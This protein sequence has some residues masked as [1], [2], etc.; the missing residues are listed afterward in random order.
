[1]ADD[2]PS[3]HGND[4][5][6]NHSRDHEDGERRVE[7]AVVEV[8][9]L[10][11]GTSVV[12]VVGPAPLSAPWIKIHLQ[13]R[14][15]PLALIPAAPTPNENG[16]T[17][18]THCFNLYQG[19][20]RDDVTT[21]TSEDVTVEMSS[22][23]TTQT[24]CVPIVYLPSDDP[25]QWRDIP[26]WIR[27]YH[28]HRHVDDIGIDPAV[29]TTKLLAHV[30]DATFVTMASPRSARPRSSQQLGNEAFVHIRIHEPPLLLRH[31][32]LGKA[33][34]H[35]EPHAD[36]DEITLSCHDV[37]STRSLYLRM[38]AL[39]QNPIHIG[40]TEDAISN[41]N[42]RN[43]Q[44]KT[45]QTDM[46]LFLHSKHHH[47]RHQKIQTQI[48]P[49]SSTPNNG[50]STN[51]SRQYKNDSTKDVE[52][53]QFL[54]EGALTV[55][56]PTHGSG[57]TRL[58]CAI[59]RQWL[60]C[61]AVHVISP[62]TLFAQ[63]GI[64]ADA[65]LESMLHEIVVQRAAQ[66]QDRICI[67]LDH[68]DAFL[69]PSMSGRR[70]DPGDPSGV[71]LNA[72][73][74]YLSKLT[75]QLRDHC[76]FP[77]PSKDPMHNLCGQ[78]G[79]IFSL[80]IC[81]VGIVTCTD[82]GGQNRTNLAASKNVLS[83]LNGGRYR[84]PVL[85]ATGRLHAFQ[86][87]FRRI[88]IGLAPE[89]SQTLS[90]LAASAV[91]ARGNVF[92]RVAQQLH[93]TMTIKKHERATVQDLV[94]AFQILRGSQWNSSSE[95]TVAESA[96]E[97]GETNPIS[98]NSTTNNTLFDSVGGNVHAKTALEDALALDPIM[99]EKL[100][101]LCM[102]APT[103]VLL[104]GPPGTG[105]TLLARAIAK[106]L[107]SQSNSNSNGAGGAE[108]TGAFLTLKAS[109]IV[110]SQVGNSEKLVVSAFET[111]RSNAPAV[112]FIDEFQALF[113]DRSG[114]GSG[115]L[116][117]T[118][119]QC[120]D[121]VT[122]WKD[123]DRDASASSFSNNNTPRV[124]VLGATNAPWMVDKAFLRPG[125]FDRVVHVGLP[126]AMERESILRV[127][128]GRMKLHSKSGTDDDTSLLVNQ[129]CT[130]LSSECH[131]FSGADL[132]ALCR[133]AAVKC[134]VE[135]N[136]SQGVQLRHF[137]EAR[138]DDVTSSSSPQLVQRLQQWRK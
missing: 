12:G 5:A 33:N 32:V 51:N 55:H 106:S 23:E 124:V 90:S 30:S 109:E 127:H 2:G 112:I 82:T 138:R 79:F 57:K 67:V 64:Q 96:A 37:D 10:H 15:P 83:V 88:R 113:T 77:F 98:P 27:G 110:R 61:D 91:T 78:N 103:G 129:I 119:L 28:T 97:P 101:A 20:K 114:G 9:P 43:S 105:K 108:R 93:E 48:I 7:L 94:E 41:W 21:S 22:D 123:A 135:R 11:L 56:D 116:A 59:A 137:Q 25:T 73:A 121:D 102:S 75:L 34:H 125:R 40:T 74:S 134:L 65:G 62:G 14:V 50:D 85:T 4:H 99:R 111:A 131:G 1:M 8:I 49:Q 19:T 31:A 104:Y 3:S 87:A 72:I 117:S 132:A 118:L 66:N 115:R 6:N 86:C 52:S 100:S 16:T 38:K 60:H 44:R 95:V 68:L 58:V 36:Q 47:P 42:T 71:V 133:A 92:Q 136:E 107:R 29:A 84:L 76:E 13:Q 130:A 70:T 46:R 35:L 69:P 17:P 53:F 128:V 26:C 122:K 18:R 89:A 45:I 120:M 54:K 39:S 81:V 126:N 24:V 63:Y 80:H